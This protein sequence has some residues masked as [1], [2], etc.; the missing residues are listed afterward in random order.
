MT[1][2]TKPQKVDDVLCAFPA[3]VSHLMPS[4]SEC[5][6]GLRALPDS[7]RGWLRFQRDWFFHGLDKA[8]EFEPKPGVDFADAV[9]HLHC[10]QGSFEPEHEHKEAAVSYLASLWFERV[11]SVPKVA[12]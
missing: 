6:E 7:G 8:T 3:H 10:I 2:W 4:R 5:E 9:R 1:D 11:P 12:A